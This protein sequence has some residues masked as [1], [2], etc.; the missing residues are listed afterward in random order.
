MLCRHGFVSRI[1]P[2]DKLSFRLKLTISGT[3]SCKHSPAQTAQHLPGDEH[4]GIFCKENDKDEA[5]E[6]RH[7]A[8]QDPTVSVFGCKIT[9]QE[10][11]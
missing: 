5:V 9:I 4:P 7:G 8:D 2:Q 3:K 1:F 6:D 10:A 11:T